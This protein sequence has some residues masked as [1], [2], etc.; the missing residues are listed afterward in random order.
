ATSAGARGILV[1]TLHE[2]AVLL[3]LRAPAVVGLEL[4]EHFLHL[5]RVR[6]LQVNDADALHFGRFLVDLRYQLLD[7]THQ[8]LRRCHEHG[9]GP[10]VGH[11]HNVRVLADVTLVVATSVLIAAAPAAASKES[12]ES[13]TAKPR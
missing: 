11:R 4:L 2:H 3:A 13:A 5:R 9:L 12:P 7:F 10:L 6:V 1:L 8:I